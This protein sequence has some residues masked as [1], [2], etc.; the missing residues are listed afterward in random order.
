MYY[1][2]NKYYIIIS[3]DVYILDKMTQPPSYIYKIPLSCLTGHI[4]TD[5]GPIRKQSTTPLLAPISG[6]DKSTVPKRSPLIRSKGLRLQSSSEQ[7]CFFKQN[8]LYQM[9]SDEH[10]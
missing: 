4:C 3:I 7:V 10:F 1:I 8:G 5:R 2:V 9:K 6:G